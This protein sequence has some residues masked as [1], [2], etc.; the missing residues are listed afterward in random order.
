MDQPQERRSLRDGPGREPLRQV[1]Q[2]LIANRRLTSCG[3]IS[4]T[5]YF[6]RV[7]DRFQRYGRA[8]ETWQQRRGQAGRPREVRD[9]GIQTSVRLVSQ[10]ALDLGRSQPE[11]RLP[12]IGMREPT[13]HPNR[14]Y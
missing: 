6:T 4:A 10:Q 3:D 9:Q 14:M 11:S 5:A 1:Q 13:D 2:H 8:E 12:G 7:H